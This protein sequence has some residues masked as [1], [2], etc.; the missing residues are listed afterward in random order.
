MTTVVERLCDI[1][2]VWT[3]GAPSTG[4]FQSEESWRTLFL[5]DMG[6]DS[7]NPSYEP[8][9]FALV[10]AEVDSDAE[11]EDILALPGIDPSDLKDMPKDKIFQTYWNRLFPI[12]KKSAAKDGV[13]YVSA[14]GMEVF[15]QAPKRH[16]VV[17][18]LK[19]RPW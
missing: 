16:L 9:Q 14:D 17:A 2:G 15:L 6:T 3:E 5:F 11:N 8:T 19:E 1:P 7:P 13:H 4:L 18:V 12:Y 10:V